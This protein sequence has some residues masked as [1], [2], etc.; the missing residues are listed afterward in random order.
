MTK[1]GRHQLGKSVFPSFE[2][3]HGKVATKVYQTTYMH[4]AHEVD[5]L[6]WK[7]F[8]LEGH[9][10]IGYFV[11]IGCEEYKEGTV[12]L[13]VGNPSPHNLPS[14]WKGYNFCEWGFM[15]FAHSIIRYKGNLV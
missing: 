7:W 5:M 8:P 1:G 13:V 12:H 14:C 4:V 2:T 10:I 9:Q 3:W 6:L 11:E 15:I